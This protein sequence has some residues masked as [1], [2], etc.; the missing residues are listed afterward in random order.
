MFMHMEQINISRIDT[1]NTNYKEKSDKSGC[2]Q[3]KNFCPSKQEV[4]KVS[5]KALV[6]GKIIT[7]HKFS[8]D[9]HPECIK[10]FH[11]SRR[12]RQKIQ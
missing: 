5:K 11:K 10:Y 12:K 2:I 8:R 6:W 4:K 9:S 3:I 7:I 1:K